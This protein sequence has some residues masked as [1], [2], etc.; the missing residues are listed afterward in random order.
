MDQGV[1]FVEFARVAKGGLGNLFINDEKVA[2]GRIEAAEPGLFS[3]D[4]TAD[5]GIGLGTPMVESIGPESRSRFNG[6]IPK[7]TVEVHAAIPAD[8]AAGD[9]AVKEAHQKI[10]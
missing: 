9:A 10:Q 2:E 8:L 4:E 1:G 5:V 3:A 7:V 6:R